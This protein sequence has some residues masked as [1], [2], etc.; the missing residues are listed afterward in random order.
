MQKL[1]SDNPG[2]AAEED[3][4]PEAFTFDEEHVDDDPSE[5]YKPPR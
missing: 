1:S 5:N 3:L 4:G 2:Q